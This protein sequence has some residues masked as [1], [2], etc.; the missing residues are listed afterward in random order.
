MRIAIPVAE[1]ELAIHFGH[2]ESFALLDIELEER[3]L[4]GRQDLSAPPHQPGLLP[5]W[6]AQK[7]VDMVI[8]GGM[9]RRAMD[10]FTSSG[11]KVFTGASSGTPEQLVHNFMHGTLSLGANHCDH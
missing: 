8:A 6:L 9:G 5:K 10:L 3:K 2:C 7:G 4:V 1:G 11:I